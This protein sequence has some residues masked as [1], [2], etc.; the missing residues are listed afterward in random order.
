MQSLVV[1]L[2]GYG[3]KTV[4]LAVGISVLPNYCSTRVNAHRDDYDGTGKR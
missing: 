1:A 3:Q 2:H 4:S